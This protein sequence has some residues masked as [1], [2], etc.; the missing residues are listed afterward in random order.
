[1][2]SSA[3]WS[4]TNFSEVLSIPWG[5]WASYLYLMRQGADMIFASCGK[6][7]KAAFVLS[8]RRARMAVQPFAYENGCMLQMYRGDTFTSPFCPRPGHTPGTGGSWGGHPFFPPIA[9]AMGREAHGTWY[10]PLP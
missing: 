6:D 3:P 2:K 10:H 9:R 7:R 1:M 4:K 8:Y 5:R